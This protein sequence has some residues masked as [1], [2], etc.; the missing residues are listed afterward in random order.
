MGNV[1]LSL[2]AGY[3]LPYGVNT[4]GTG[5]KLLSGVFLGITGAYG[6]Q[7]QSK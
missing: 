2:D 6:K 5:D 4:N 3:R 7:M 1:H